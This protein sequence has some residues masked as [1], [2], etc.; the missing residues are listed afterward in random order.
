MIHGL[1]TPPDSKRMSER[2]GEPCFGPFDRGRKVLSRRKPS[3]DCGGE[4]APGS[5]KATWDDF[6]GRELGDLSLV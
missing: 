2:A 4:C 6:G 1:G 3:R 5:V